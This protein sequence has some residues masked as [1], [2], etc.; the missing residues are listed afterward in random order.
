MSRILVAVLAVIL[1]CI[2]CSEK[3]SFFQ[4]S[5]LV[6]E[7][8]LVDRADLDKPYVP[9]I[10]GGSLG[11]CDRRVLVFHADS[12]VEIREMQ[13][14]TDYSNPYYSKT[15]SFPDYKF[16]FAI[17]QD[18]LKI[19]QDSLSFFNF[20]DSTWFIGMPI[21]RLT[22]DTLILQTG[23][24]DSLLYRRAAPLPETLPV[25]DA[26]VLSATNS[27]CRSTTPII[28]IMIRADGRV[29]FHCERSIDSTGIYKATLTPEQYATIQN[30]FRRADI[31]NTEMDFF[32]KERPPG[33]EQ[34]SITFLKDGRI[35]KTITDYG[36]SAPADL[37]WAI[38]RLRHLYLQLALTKLADSE[39]SVY[40]NMRPF[41]LRHGTMYYRITPSESFLLWSYL[42]KGKLTAEHAT[43]RNL[44]ISHIT[45]GAFSNGE[46]CT[47][48]TD[49]QRYT[50]LVK[51]KT[52]VTIDIGFNFIEQNLS[53][54]GLFD[55]WPGL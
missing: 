45:D 15:F 35:Y 24:N 22:S 38:V 55:P 6:G 7:W 12:T 43:G 34:I 54:F 27:Y 4:Y 51:G 50:F 21:R 5:D 29:L 36:S 33:S 17:R 53:K 3:K 46:S 9:Y 20:E 26:I 42:R 10:N 31:K 30:L 49:G 40:E 28:N 19:L 32:Y 25:F 13:I 16:P 37:M 1:L 52:P 14:K 44:Y 47:M 41:Y 39:L 48:K 8:E 23:E 18:S 11:P 2:G